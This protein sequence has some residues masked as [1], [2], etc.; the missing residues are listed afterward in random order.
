MVLLQG[1][2]FVLKQGPG[3]EMPKGSVER[4]GAAGMGA[5]SHT[6][7][8]ARAVITLFIPGTPLQTTPLQK[9]A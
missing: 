4:Q 9:R 7:G 5:F 6:A 1:N 2:A 8:T 3:A